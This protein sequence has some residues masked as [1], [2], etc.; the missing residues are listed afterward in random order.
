MNGVFLVEFLYQHY[1]KPDEKLYLYTNN[2]ENLVSFGQVGNYHGY[3]EFSG[4]KTTLTVW[5]NCYGDNQWKIKPCVYCLLP[6]S[7]T[8]WKNMTCEQF[9]DIRLTELVRKELHSE[10]WVHSERLFKD[11]LVSTEYVAIPP[12]RPPTIDVDISSLPADMPLSVRLTTH[13]VNSDGTTDSPMGMSHHDNLALHAVENAL[14][15]TVMAIREGA[16]QTDTD[17]ESANQTT[18]TTD[19]EDGS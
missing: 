12:L 15:S 8:Q 13:Q 2:G 11:M 7:S 9:K 6:F 18:T 1:G 14:M 16:G 19:M 3:W 5:F 4:Q 17:R 10:G